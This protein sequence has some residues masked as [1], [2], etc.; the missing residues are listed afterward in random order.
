M[1]GLDVGHVAGNNNPD[2]IATRYGRAAIGNGSGASKFGEPLGVSVAPQIPFPMEWVSTNTFAASNMIVLAYTFERTI[3]GRNGET[4]Q[5]V[6]PNAVAAD[7]WLHGV[8]GCARDNQTYPTDVLSEAL[9]E[10][11]MTPE[12]IER[13]VELLVVGRGAGVFN[14]GN[15]CFQLKHTRSLKFAL[16]FGAIMANQSKVLKLQEI[17]LRMEGQNN[18]RDA[19]RNI[20]R[21]AAAAQTAA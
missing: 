11:L 5:F 6:E 10:E 17:M 9:F 21:L 16:V 13:L 14:E 19:R 20:E 1:A 4:L 3:M 15:L 7:L 2:R 8:I 12:S 18:Y